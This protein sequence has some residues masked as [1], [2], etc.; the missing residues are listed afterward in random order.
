MASRLKRLREAAGL[1]Q[2][3]LAREADVSLRAVQ[4]WEYGKRTFSF[5]TALILADALGCTLYE[6]A[7]RK[8][9][10]PKKSR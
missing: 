1:T 10:G 8:E 6:L 5:E 4:H 2:A 9:P 7:G 3:D